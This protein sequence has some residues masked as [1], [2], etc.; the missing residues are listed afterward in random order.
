MHKI[1]RYFLELVITSTRFITY[2]SL[3][4]EVHYTIF[5]NVL[6]KLE[7]SF[8]TNCVYEATFIYSG[9]LRDITLKFGGKKIACRDYT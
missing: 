5:W 6:S 1:L 4:E 9:V 7:K 2:N 8:I 3:D